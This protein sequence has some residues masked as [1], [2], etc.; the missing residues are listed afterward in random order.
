MQPDEVLERLLKIR[1]SKISDTGRIV[2]L[3]RASRLIQGKINDLKKEKRYLVRKALMLRAS[4]KYSEF[5]ARRAQQLVLES[6]SHREPELEI[7][8][9]FLAHIGSDLATYEHRFD[10][11]RLEQLFDLLNV[12]RKDRPRFRNEL[13]QDLTPFNTLVFVLGAED[14]LEQKKSPAKPRASSLLSPPPAL[15][16]DGPLFCAC[17]TRIAQ[18][19][20]AQAVDCTKEIS[21]LLE[22]FKKLSKPSHFGA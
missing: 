8:N 21:K 1:L 20:H 12:H 13:K 14:S 3:R 7:L 6:Y 22:R 19:P 5:S 9:E 15:G 16:R 10:R 18:M 17:L 4:T 2:V 11:L